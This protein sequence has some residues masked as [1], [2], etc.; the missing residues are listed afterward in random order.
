MNAKYILH[1]TSAGCACLALFFLGRYTGKSSQD[2]NGAMDAGVPR[3]ESIGI[4]ESVSMP[5][6]D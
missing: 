3:D 1:A 2:A 6:I 4:E 5:A